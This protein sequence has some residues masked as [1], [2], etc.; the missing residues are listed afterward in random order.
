MSLNFAQICESVFNELD[1]LEEADKYV[2]DDLSRKA[3]RAYIAKE[4]SNTP[5]EA[6]TQVQRLISLRT[7]YIREVRTPNL[8]AS[9][10]QR[11]K[12]EN[13]TDEDVEAFLKKK[14]SEEKMEHPRVHGTHFLTMDYLSKYTGANA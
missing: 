9:P 7:A 6:N 3:Y 1:I 5:E 8:H 13:L 10:E 14:A 12:I 11:Q 4:K 2:L